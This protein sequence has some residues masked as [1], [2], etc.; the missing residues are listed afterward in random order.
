MAPLHPSLVQGGWLCPSPLEKIRSP[1]DK[2]LVKDFLS[3]TSELV[4]KI[5]LLGTPFDHI[6]IPP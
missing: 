2:F 4:I 3:Q 1:P 5:R 6:A